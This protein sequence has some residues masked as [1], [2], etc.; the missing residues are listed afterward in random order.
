MN[1][2]KKYLTR[3]INK[4]CDYELSHNEIIGITLSIE[5]STNNES[6]LFLN[7]TL[8]KH[9]ITINMRKSITALMLEEIEMIEERN[10]PNP[11][12]VKTNNNTDDMDMDNINF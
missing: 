10:K 3:I 6:L 11:F 2:I 1:T 12:I 9:G 4:H 5:E 8:K 7:K